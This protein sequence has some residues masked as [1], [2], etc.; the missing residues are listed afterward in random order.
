MTQSDR[1]SN[2]LY[3]SPLGN[4]AWS[5]TLPDPA[6]DMSD[7]PLATLQAACDR[8]SAP[9]PSAGREATIW[10]RAGRY[11]IAEPLKLGPEHSG[12]RLFACPGE[13]VVIDG[14][15]RI[16]H[17]RK[18][19]V[20]NRPAWVA[21][22]PESAG[23]E[24]HIRSLYVNG[25]RRR[26]PRL[27]KQGH[28]WMEDVPG[29][30]PTVHFGQQLF[31]G[32]GRFRYAEG[33]IRSWR[34][35]SDVDIVVNHMWIDERMPVASVDEQAR[36]V[37]STHKS[38]FVLKDDFADRFAQYYVENVYEALSE[39]GEWYFD[40]SERQLIYL[41]F[42]HERPDET[43]VV[44]PVAEQFIRVEGLPERDRLA[45]DIHVRG[46]VFRHAGWH[47]PPVADTYDIQSFHPDFG[48]EPLAATPQA[49]VHV[50]GTINFLGAR[51]CSVEQCRIEHIGFYGIHIGEACRDIRIAHNTIRDAGAGGIKAAGRGAGGPPALRT[52]RLTI[53]DN[54]ISA[55]G[56]V[57]HGA[58]GIILMHAHDNTVT[59]N[60]VH[61]L[62][63]T[64]ISCGWV[65]GYADNVSAN[66]LI[67]HNWIHDIGQGVL[68]DMGGVYVLGVQPGTV[69]RGNLIHDVRK[70]NY[71]GWGIYLDEG[72]SH[73][74]VENNICFRTSSQIF[75]QHYGRENIVR[76]NVF[77]CGGEGTIALSRSEDHL[78]LTFM[79]N[80]VYAD[81]DD[82][83]FV[84]GSPELLE[85]RHFI[86]DLNLFVRR[87]PAAVMAGEGTF[88]DSARW[89]YSKRY[90]W[91]EWAEMGYD[92][93]SA[94]QFAAPVPDDREL[95]AL[96]AEPS[97]RALELGFRAIDTSRFGPRPIESAT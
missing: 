83:V 51:G 89:V 28:Y 27:P 46:I 75:H 90:D 5:G 38:V 40:R 55:G 87:S 35:L 72:S 16:V 96:A 97:E 36:I 44:A 63:Y 17:W 3:V 29:I 68:S 15:R 50:P 77:A 20:C 86:S 57:F 62:Y 53:T 31:N 33:D 56:R 41:P 13:E 26:R 73:V 71:G 69:V 81:D 18:T 2:E 11:A 59:H 9:F 66:N 85:R 6:G 95:L 43:V 24:W 22:I 80:V 42:E 84:G 76:N 93:H 49:A 79:H 23:R 12:L 91:S 60:H 82:A 45:E 67:A 34:N 92:R 39:P 21:D 54:E 7:G 78:S 25:E 19:T 14:G 88:D 94:T 64:G 10:L 47:Q 61:D 4:D 48:A 1:Y 58:V 8:I 65:W 32:S 30:D 52:G 37:Q 70:K 74:V